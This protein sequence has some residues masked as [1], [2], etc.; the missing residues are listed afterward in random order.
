MGGPACVVFLPVSGQL[1]EKVGSFFTGFCHRLLARR[2]GIAVTAR[3]ASGVILLHRLAKLV[4]GLALKLAAPLRSGLRAAACYTGHVNPFAIRRVD[5]HHA[6]GSGRHALQRV[7]T[8]K[9]HR[10]GH[11]GAFGI[12]L[13][14]VHHP[15]SH[16]AAEHQRR[17]LGDGGFGLVQQTVPDVGL[18]RQVFLKRKLAVDAGRD[19]A[20]NLRRFNRNRAR[21]AARVVQRHAVFGQLVPAA[22]RNHGSGQSFFERRV[23]LVFTP[24]ALEQRLAGG[25]DV[26]RHGIDCQ[27]RVNPHIGPARVDIGAHVKFVPEAVGHCVLDLER[28]KVQAGQ[29]A[30]LGGDFNLEGLL[31]REPDFPGH[32]CGRVVKILLT[33]VLVVRQLDQHPL[34]QTAVQIELQGIAPRAFKLHTG[35]PGLAV[36]AGDAFDLSGQQCFDASG[37]GKEELELVHECI[38]GWPTKLQNDSFQR[39]AAAE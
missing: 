3:L 4:D 14:K 32:R 34:R 29:R 30:V 20:G 8:A 18:K 38:L 27:M 6:A 39:G 12:A 22:G 25:V 9:L 36:N 10:V 31:G 7:A 24:A 35:P 17:R 37:A 21:S 11:T 1:R 23:A 2:V 16:I 15:E 33:A 28:R 19:I 26:N 13:G 5:Q